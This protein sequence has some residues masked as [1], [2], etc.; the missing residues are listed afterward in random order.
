MPKNISEPFRFDQALG[1]TFTI[2]FREGN[3]RG[4]QE[5]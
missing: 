3:A 2:K 5:W 1:K 4:S